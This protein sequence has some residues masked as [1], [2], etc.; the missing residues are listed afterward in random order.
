MVLGFFSIVHTPHTSPS[1]FSDTRHSGQSELSY[2]LGMNN[3]EKQ[4]CVY[5]SKKCVLP[6]HLK[7]MCEGK[8]VA[9]PKAL[10]SRRT[11]CSGLWERRQLLSPLYFLL[12][13]FAGQH[14]NL[15]CSFAAR[16]LSYVRPQK[17]QS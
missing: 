4:W 9:L 15:Q 16:T 8:T 11:R 12:C 13:L 17:V 7:A 6:V 2:V 3:T 1:F 14:F 10:H 5:T